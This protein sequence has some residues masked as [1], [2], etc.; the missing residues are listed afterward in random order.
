[1]CE[2]KSFS[3]NLSLSLSVFSLENTPQSNIVK[4][5]TQRLFIS[6]RKD[7]FSLIYIKSTV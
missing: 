1:M 6:C 2:N 7:M 3:L 5:S 4:L